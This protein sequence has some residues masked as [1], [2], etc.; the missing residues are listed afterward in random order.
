MPIN[1]PSKL[2]A[3]EPIIETVAVTIILSIIFHGIS[4]NP[5]ARADGERLKQS[6]GA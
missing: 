2:P 6:G 4:A 3:I 1:V 5:W